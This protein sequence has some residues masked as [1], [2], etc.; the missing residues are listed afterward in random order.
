MSE[1]MKRAMHAHTNLNTFATIV[2]ILEGGM[3]YGPTSDSAGRTAKKVLAICLQ[4]QQRQLKAM[5]KAT[6]RTA[7]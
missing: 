3:V 4:E 6:G 1:P 5:D 2:R 7:P